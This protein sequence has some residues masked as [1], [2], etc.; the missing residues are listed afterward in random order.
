MGEIFNIENQINQDPFL[1]GSKEIDKNI[2]K[3]L[4][5]RFMPELFYKQ[6]LIFLRQIIF[7][8]ISKQKKRVAKLVSAF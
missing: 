3:E 8:D 7:I 5:K 6:F 2:R 4:R 1:E